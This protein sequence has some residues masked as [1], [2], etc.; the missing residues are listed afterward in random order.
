MKFGHFDDVNKEYVIETPRTPLPW[1]N[2]LG[3]KDFFSLISNT[4]GGY[5][6]YKDAKLRR[7]TRYRYNNVPND[8][9]GRF[10]YINDNNQIWNP[11]YLPVKTKLDSYECHHGLGYSRFLSSK[12][13]LSSNLL[14]FVPDDDCE[15]NELVLTNNSKEAKSFDLYSMVEFCLWNA[16]DDSTNF[17]RN[18]NIAEVEVDD[19]TIY[20]K[21]EY[22]ERRN[23]YSFYYSNIKHDGFDTDR[24]EFLG[25]QNGF[26]APECVTNKIS[27]NSVASGGEP[28][29]CHHYKVSL[30]PGESE[31]FIFI[32]GYIENK[33]EDKFVGDNIINK[34]K[35][36]K[37]I[38]RFNTSDK[39]NKAFNKLNANWTDLLSTFNIKTNEEKFDRMAN[40]W[41][42]Y[43]CMITYCMSRS[44]SYFE[45][46]TGRGMGFRD[47][48]QDILGF[49][50]LI[51][52]KAKERII[53]IASIQYK[54]G[55]TYH[56]YQPLT[57]RGNADVGSGFNDDPLWLIA[58]TSA[59]IK[60]TGDLSI[61]DVPTP[62]NNEFGSEVPLYNHLLASIN[63]TIT[64]QGPHG[65][66][67]I[68]RADWND[69]LNLNCFSKTPGESF[70]TCSNFESNKAE[71]V[72]IAGMFVK[73]G[74]EFIEIAKLYSHNDDAKN[75][76][77]AVESIE[78]NTIKYG[79]D[80]KW[81]L[82][83]YDAYSSKVGSDE[84]KEGKIFI[85]PQGFCTYAGIGSSLN[86]GKMA[87]SSVK[88]Y[89][90]ND[91]GIEL[92]YPP[93]SKYHLELG[94]ISSYIP[95][96][97]EN[98][99][100]FCH[101]NPW[102]TLACCKEG[103]GDDAFSLYK[104]NAPAYIEDKSEIHM[105]EPYVYSQTIAGRFSAHYGRAKNSWLTG[106]ASWSFV[107][108]SQGILGIIPTLDGLMI[109]PC[110]P[111]EMKHINIKRI[112]RNATY[113]IE[114]INNNSK[115]YELK[116]D[117]KVINGKVIPIIN[118][119]TTYNVIVT[120]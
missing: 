35:A 17:Q 120:K 22:R 104:K 6:F 33:D 36:I 19:N 57:K 1:I 113:N 90:V 88:E 108:L 79:W 101:N 26:D 45:S 66:P 92:L 74:K 71:S 59:Y 16:V 85:E 64:H 110:L 54:D 70:Q 49:V 34:S 98:G 2:Y 9:S 68:G 91:Y 53:D 55:S 117:G 11:A 40:I 103:L 31:T 13:G 14:C 28:I 109:D 115:N 100:V 67:L 23:H 61:L 42:Q 87:L 3:N 51:P 111:K 10:I 95:G 97:K 27:H 7:I 18:L 32:L 30:K 21:T 46:G 37:M 8:I 65:L 84:N 50:H 20:H 38:N 96:N 107:A 48:C 47:S 4:C 102:I 81:F 83:A 52:L 75:T 114:I 24:D 89:L 44:A 58:A 119:K 106:T 99:S 39:I 77:I 76:L 82:R 56:Q 80:G 62:F 93:Y 63:Y 105:T 43:Q 72:F 41:N 78:N 60:E 29:G 118:T 5:S 112:Y 12:N 116:V 69:C 15:L 86:Y 25:L 94:E 73:Y